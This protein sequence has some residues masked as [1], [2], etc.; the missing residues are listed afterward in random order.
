[1]PPYPSAI[2]RHS[3]L[4]GGRVALA[5]GRG[6]A[7]QNKSTIAYDHE[8]EPCSLGV[9]HLPVLLVLPPQC[10]TLTHPTQLELQF[11]DPLRCSTQ[12]ASGLRII[13]ALARRVAAAAS[14]C[15]ILGGVVAQLACLECR[16]D[17]DRPMLE[18]LLIGLLYILLYAVVA[19]IIVYVIVY[20]AAAFGFPLPAPIPKLLWAIV[21]IICLIMLISLLM[22]WNPRFRVEHPGGAVAT[23]APA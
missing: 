11:V 6:A 3:Y 14:S 8:D 13:P 20:A 7:W 2:E 23:S 16:H 15:V 9:L 4:Q 19:S 21:A 12:Q 10:S 22:G 17:R 1:M 5:P 18:G